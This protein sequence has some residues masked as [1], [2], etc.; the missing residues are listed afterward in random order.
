MDVQVAVLA[1]AANISAQ[2]KLNILGAFERIVAQGFPALH[3]SMALVLR[4]KL[5]YEDGRGLHTL[6]V[7]FRDEDGREG[8][9]ATA[10]VQVGEIP[11]GGF[12]STNQILNFAAV[13]FAKAGHYVFEVFW[14]E[15]SKARVDLLVMGP[16]DKAR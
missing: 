6:R 13:Q 11:P 4:L 15:A 8:G 7:T 5:G 2:G 10:D 14:D 16:P 9:T 12:I 1:D 3:P